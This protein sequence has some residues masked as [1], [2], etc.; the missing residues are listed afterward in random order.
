MSEPKPC[1]AC[2]THPA[3]VFDVPVVTLSLEVCAALGVAH[4]M[5]KDELLDLCDACLKK[6]SA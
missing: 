5:G 4:E 2:R 6:A 3:V 1:T